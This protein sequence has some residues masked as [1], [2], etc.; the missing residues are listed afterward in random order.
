MRPLSNCGMLSAVLC[1]GGG[2]LPALGGRLSFTYE[3]E[4]D[5]SFRALSR[6]KGG[7]SME[8]SVLLQCVDV[9]CQVLMTVIAAIALERNDKKK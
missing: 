3:R 4:L 6:R 5:F 8:L 2:R 7:G 9:A 1:E